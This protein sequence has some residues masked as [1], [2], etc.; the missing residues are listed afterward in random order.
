MNVDRFTARC[1]GLV[2]RSN[3]ARRVV[4]GI[5]YGVAAAI[6]IA[7]AV[8]AF[9]PGFAWR[10]GVPT[11]D[12]TA[13]VAEYPVL[14]L[15]LAVLIVLIPRALLGAR[16]ALAHVLVWSLG[17]FGCSV[18]LMNLTAWQPLEVAFGGCGRSLWPTDA[19][20]LLLRVLAG[21]HLV[22]IPLACA[23]IAIAQL[24]HW[25]APRLPHAKVLRA[26]YTIR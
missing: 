12:E 20:G 22:V 24:A 8:L 17:S 23:A 7:V 10:V 14:V 15:V 4:L 13:T 3:R 11:Y 5:C 6:A 18:L 21:L 19:V 9:F 16:P 2:R 26:R 1:D 25:K